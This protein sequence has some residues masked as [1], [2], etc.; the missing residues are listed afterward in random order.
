MSDPQTK[1]LRVA[2]YARVST[3]EQREGQTID[4]QIAE[5][6]RFIKDKGWAVTAVYKDE[7]WSGSI[8]A[9][10]ALD[11][12]RDDSTKGL[13]DAAIVNDVDR[14]ARDVAH[15]GIIKRDFERKRVQLIFR[16]LPGE[17]SPT[18]NLMVNILG[19]FAEFE[20]EIIIDRTR[21][22]RRHKVEARKQYVGCVAA[23]GYHYETKSA[24]N[25]NDARLD[26]VPEEA[27]VVKQIY[28]W[29]L[30][31]LSM[32]KTTRRLNELGIPPRK[33]K[34]GWNV[35]T[36]HRIVRN[37]MYAGVWSYG[38][39]EVCEPERHRTNNLYRRTTKTSR[40]PKPRS[41][42]FRVPLPDHLRIIAPSV[43][44]QVQ[45]QV[46]RN[47]KFSPRNSKI[48]YLL[49]GL[50]KCG[51]CG[52]ACGGT[53]SR[54]RGKAYPYYRCWRRQCKASRWT[55][56]AVLDSVV[57]STLESAL[58]NPTHLAKRIN[59]AQADLSKQN[60]QPLP[61]P[62]TT[63]EE[64]CSDEESR[65]FQRYRTGQISVH[66][67][68]TDLEAL[69]ERH[70][71]QSQPAR[72]KPKLDQSFEDSCRSVAAR[73]HNAAPEMKQ[74]IIRRLV[75]EAVVRID[76]IKIRAKIESGPDATEKSA[77]IVDDFVSSKDT[78][79]PAG[80]DRGAA[81][82]LLQRYRCNT[83][84]VEFEL[85]APLP[86]PAPNT[87]RSLKERYHREALSR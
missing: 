83:T 67:M 7:G 6:E 78:G 63:L 2:L 57:W 68:A 44:S 35:C 39:R 10:P 27:R 59:D 50:L 84:M 55:S 76:H 79:I 20:R 36:V 11:R 70:R 82:S 13:F 16:K 49:R 81:S 85:I 29:V 64:M 25:G 14:L 5:I 62:S 66:Q 32:E 40:R 1:Q 30:Q 72:A 53:V 22:G 80:S 12:L 41:E 4:A 31:G 58:L 75:L 45:A 52:G 54:Y 28:E 34:N 60:S 9:R 38:K 61:N 15:L 8:L 33:G 48:A 69:R 56:M 73:L 18:Y 86:A 71:E 87:K 65:L 26:I 3:E 43:W 51:Y 23:Y 24:T 42:W 74:T 17:S 47:P 21:R 19:S 37:E 46:D 77:G